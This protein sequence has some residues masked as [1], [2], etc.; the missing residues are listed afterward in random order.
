MAWPTHAILDDLFSHSTCIHMYMFGNKQSDDTFGHV[1]F[2]SL[3]P[4]PLQTGKYPLVMLH[5]FQLT[6]SLFSD[7]LPIVHISMVAIIFSGPLI[8]AGS[9][10]CGC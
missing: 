9:C 1:H 8:R 5:F 10:G 4:P 6:C 7:T 3:P 2:I